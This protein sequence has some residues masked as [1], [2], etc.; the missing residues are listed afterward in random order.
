MDVD[1]LQLARVPSRKKEIF[2]REDKL[3]RFVLWIGYG[4]AQ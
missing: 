3:F 1:Y 4:Q 2:L